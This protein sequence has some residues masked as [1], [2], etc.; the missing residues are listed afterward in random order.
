MKLKCGG[1][2]KQLTIQEPDADSGAEI[3]VL[4]PDAE[5]GQRTVIANPKHPKP[6]EED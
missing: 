4:C 3:I 1:C 5:C 2:A 6:E